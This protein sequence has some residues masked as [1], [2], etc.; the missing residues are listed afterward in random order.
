M[1]LEDAEVL[2]EVEEP[3][4]GFSIDGLRIYFKQKDS[5]NWLTSEQVT[6][7]ARK[8][9]ATSDISSRNAIVESFLTYA[10]KVAR[11]Y[12]GKGLELDDL[13]QEANL[14]LLRAAE[15]FDPELGFAFMT[16]AD[17]WLHL[18]ADD[19]VINHSRTVRIPKHVHRQFRRILRAENDLW[20]RGGSI[21]LQ[22]LSAIT[23]F[24][25]EKIRQIKIDFSG[26][27]PFEEIM[28]YNISALETAIN[29]ETFAMAKSEYKEILREIESFVGIVNELKISTAMKR[30]FLMKYGLH[31]KKYKQMASV[32]IA[33][34]EEVDISTVNNGI[35][36]IWGKLSSTEN[37]D[38]KWL[39]G[40]LIRRIFLKKYSD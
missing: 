15:K 30:R 27:E 22:E 5:I 2:I 12:Q 40:L 37:L 7:H 17:S 4:E 34:Q 35:R 23:G 13:I 32:D 29:P 28:E 11:K 18:F 24:S 10:I 6:E 39:E 19:G 25:Q 20:K 14:G 16:Y 33:T 9:Q 8:V 21:D 3:E 36:A 1:T 38:K 31:N 26:Y